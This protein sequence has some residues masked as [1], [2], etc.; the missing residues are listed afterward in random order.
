M[1]P[2]IVYLAQNTPKDTQYGRDSRTLLEK[3]LNLLYLN[4]NQQFRHDIIIF[5]EGDFDLGDQE[6]VANGR[7][8]I[9]FHQI[10]FEIP[11]FLPAVEVPEVWDDGFG[12]KFGL[13][14]RHMIRFYAVQ[15]FHILAE[16]GYD[17]FFRMDDDS[18]IHTPIRYDMFEFMA[19]NGYEYGY[20]VDIRDAETS[21]RGFGEAVLAYTKA[22]RINPDF[23][24]EHLRP[25]PVALQM[26]N[27]VKTVLM[28]L[29]PGTKFSL[30]P[31]FEYDLL[32]YYTNFF[33][34]PISFWLRQDV[35]AFI[36]SFDRFGGWYKYRW[37]DL[38]FQSAAVQLFLPKSKVY[39]FTDWTY[40]H[41]TI[42]KGKL[43]WGGIYPA[44]GERRSKVVQEFKRQYPTP[45][46]FAGRSH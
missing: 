2:A 46:W 43:F 41:A 7:K 21:A 36:N 45:R 33:I 24:Q 30:R 37:N 14:H 22:E 9:K 28:K 10:R 12:V 40:E 11:A 15:I 34:T 42:K 3:S 23:F 26:L 20:R 32:G 31:A 29:A 27:I 8:E 19:K 44:T 6:A 1:K 17:W 38:I 18:F 13:G 16:L 39:K 5:H 25:A 35:Q 4:Y